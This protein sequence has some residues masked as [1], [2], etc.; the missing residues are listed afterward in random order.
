[1]GYAEGFA[2][3]Q[4]LPI[5]KNCQ[6]R[7]DKIVNSGPARAAEM[8]RAIDNAHLHTLF[9]P[10]P[11]VSWSETQEVLGHPTSTLLPF[12]NRRAAVSDEIRASLGNW[13]MNSCGAEETS[14]PAAAG[15]AEVTFWDSF[16]TK[17]RTKTGKSVFRNTITTVI[18]HDVRKHN[19]VVK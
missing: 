12:E 2:P 8:L 1:M 3:G 11:C 13:A 7:T 19:Q 10:S 17:Q 4:R 14:L 16:G 9:D 5:D 15:K 6:L 18:F